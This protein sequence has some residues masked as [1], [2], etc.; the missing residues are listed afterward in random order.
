MIKNLYE[1]SPKLRNRL[2]VFL[3]RH[4]LEK[5]IVSFHRFTVESQNFITNIFNNGPITDQSKCKL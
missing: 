4:L 3:R 5:V 2:L 1:E